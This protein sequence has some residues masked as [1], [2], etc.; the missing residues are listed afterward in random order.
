[1]QGK[2]I[3]VLLA[4]FVVAV[5]V[6]LV[7]ASV[8][9]YRAFC[10]VTGAG[11]TPQVAAAAPGAQSA[12]TIVVRFDTSVAR[13]M[14]WR[15]E[16]KQR[17]MSVHLGEQALAV[18]TATNESDEPVVGNATF[19]ITPDKAGK[20]FDKI[21]CFC[22]SEQ[23]LEPHQSVDMPVVFF[24]DPAIAT[25]PHTGEVGTLTLS[26]TFFRRALPSPAATVKTGGPS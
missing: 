20:Y 15:F 11:G 4:V 3:T 23:R 26:Y 5:M 14:P 9:L 2:R 21:Q 10:R 7:S 16:P 6:G 13:G 12:R 17:S 24:V 18:F 22:F 8:P 25:D 19:N 1:M